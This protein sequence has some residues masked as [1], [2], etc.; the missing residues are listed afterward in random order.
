MTHLLRYVTLSYIKLRFKLYFIFDIFYILLGDQ[1][2]CPRTECPELKLT[3]IRV[4]AK[5]E[6]G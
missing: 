6:V 1:K 4:M 5:V 2:R 3:R